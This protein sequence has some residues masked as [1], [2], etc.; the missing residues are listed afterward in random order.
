MK[1]LHL[2]PSLFLIALASHVAGKT[3]PN[4]AAADL[5][6]GKPDFVTA[7]SPLTNSFSLSDPMAIAIDPVSQKVFVSDRGDHRILRYANASALT[8]GAGAEAVF[9]QT[10]FSTSTSG[11]SDLLLNNPTSMFLDRRGRLWVA[12]QGNSRVLVYEAASYRNSQAADRVYGQPNFT[13][14]SSAT[15]AS[16]MSSPYGVCVDS[17]DNLWVGDTGNNRV[18][19]FSAISTKASG[20]AA[21]SVLG[22]A[23]FLTNTGATTATRMTGPVG[24]TISSAGTLYVGCSG[25]HRVLRFN[26]AAAL[27]NGAAASGVLGQLDFTT[28]TLG[29]SATKLADPYGVWATQDDALWVSDFGNNRILRFDAASTKADGAAA[30]G[31]VGQPN[32]DVNTP[33]LTS[34]NFGQPFVSPFVD[35]AGSLWISEEMNDRVL[36]FPADVTLP[37]LTVTTVVPK[38]TKA[39]KLTLNGTASDANGVTLVQF[40]VN[41]GPLQTATGTTTWQIKPALKKGK[42]TITLF[43]TDTV[44]NLSVS[45]VLKT[46]RK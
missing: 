34:R 18:L 36:R 7:T 31:V 29:L 17:N 14:S 11:T 6:L 45:T 23:T 9:G 25:D 20:A 27:G 43:A 41:A 19:K 8:N 33:G 13:T 5:V 28:A 21:D 16:K 4:N 39:K 2:F 40:K 35:A 12:D 10:S 15:T 44:G 24:V 42:N 3:I 38:T 32:F 46:K 37:L 26:N 22:Q 30:N 1:K